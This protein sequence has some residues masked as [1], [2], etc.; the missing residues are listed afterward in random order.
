MRNQYRLWMA[1][2]LCSVVVNC[3]ERSRNAEPA[4]PSAYIISD[5]SQAVRIDIP[6][7]EQNPSAALMLPPGFTEPGTRVVFQRRNTPEDWAQ[8]QN[9]ELLGS[10]YIVTFMGPDGKPAGTFGA[11]TVRF[12]QDEAE[13]TAWARAADERNLISLLKED[14]YGLRY[15]RVLEQSVRINQNMVLQL[16]VPQAGFALLEDTSSATSGLEP[17]IRQDGAI[18]QCDEKAPTTSGNL[19]LSNVAQTSLTVSWAA[20]TDETTVQSALKYKLVKASSSSEIDSIT[21]AVSRVQGDILLD[22]TANTLSKNVSGL[23]EGTAYHFA[24]LVKDETGNLSLYPLGTTTTTTTPV[25]TAPTIGTAIVSSQITSSSVTLTWGA[26]SDTVT[27]TASLQYKLVRAS[28]SAAIDS[29]AEADAITGTGLVMDWAANTLTDSVSGLDD[30]TTYFFAVLV[31]NNSGLKAIYSPVSITTVVFDPADP[32]ADPTQ[33]DVVAVGNRHSCFILSDGAMKC[34]G[35]NTSGQ[36]GDGSTTS[37]SSPVQA[38]TN[39]VKASA[40]YTHTCAIVSD[41]SIRCWGSNASGQLGTGNTT[42]QTSPV[43]VSGLTSVKQISLGQNHSCALMN[44]GS[45]YCWGDNSVGQLGDGSNTQRLTPTAVSGISTAISIDTQKNHTCAVLADK[46]VRCWG[47]NTNGK[48]GNGNATNSNVP[49]NPGLSDVLSVSAGNEHSCAVLNGGT[50][51][52]WGD[53]GLGQL[54]TGSTADSN[55][56]VTVTEVANG[57][58]FVMARGERSCFAL[59]AGGIKC[60]GFGG[61]GQLGQGAASNSTTAVSVSGITEVVT[62]MK[63]NQ[64]HNCLRTSSGTFRCWGYNNSSQVGDGTTTQANAPVDV[65]GL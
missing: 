37:R 48:L 32:A 6:A 25:S 61:Q 53:G 54:G 60:M 36:L 49:V 5:A 52:C 10:T 28:S 17:I 9:V 31:K 39:V 47:E 1:S 27:A 35:L 58:S 8:I 41:E 59:A 13:L 45:I 19:T 12:Y 64:D 15:R 57:I 22:W 40:G 11:A 3:S 26:A 46:T 20:A 30:G 62:G 7:D 34:V 55:V 4:S 24:V 56:P 18:V 50:A 63:A 33:R 42:S 14:V 23:T 44:S 21:K 43:T 29:V 16:A 51:K 38:L 65:L 2:L